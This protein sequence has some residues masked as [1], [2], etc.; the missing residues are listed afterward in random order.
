MQLLVE[1]LNPDQLQAV[2]VALI[3]GIAVIA[4][5]FA[6]VKYQL[7]LLADETSLRR[8]KQEGE[9]AIRSKIIEKIAAG[10]SPESLLR[11]EKAFYN[12]AAAADLDG[13]DTKLAKALGMLELPA[14]QIEEMLTRTLALDSSRK[15]SVI[16]TIQELT[17][18]G[19]EHKSIVAAIRALCAKVPAGESGRGELI[20]AHSS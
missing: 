20:S 2:I 8:E 14:D 18:E 16:S 1:R 19:A 4:V 10:A 15:Q 9:L 13:Q 17:D 12:A 5:T 11:A 7:Q 3:I 6:I